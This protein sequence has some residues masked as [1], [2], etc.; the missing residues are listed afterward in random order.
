MAEEAAPKD[1]KAWM[2]KED[3]YDNDLF[4]ILTSQGIN[5][6]EEDFK[7]YTQGQW[8]ELWRKGCV[9]R[10]KEL[11]DQKAKV[12]LEK[13][14]TKLEKYW[15]KQSGV[16]STSIKKKGKKKSDTLNNSASAKNEA[17]AS[18]NEIK[19]YLKK[20]GCFSP[21]LVEV[22][23]GVGITSK[24]D[25]TNITR[26][27]YDEIFRQIRVRR[28]Q[29]LKDNAA[30]VRMEKMMEKFAKLC[31]KE[32]R[33]KSA[34]SK[35]GGKGKKKKDTPKDKEIQKMQSG[36]AK[37]KAWMRKNDVWEM[38]LYEELMANDISEAE[39]LKDIGQ[40]LFDN[41]V[42]KVRVD[43]FSQLKDQK[44]RNRA[45]KLLIKFEKEWRKASGIKKTSLKN[46]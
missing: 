6:P 29:D 36:G 18:G 17:L 46:K 32:I 41:I 44:A 14:M 42:R 2:R 25:L 43:R 33:T 24:D 38:A 20:E 7:T 16:K 1:L 30:R 37:L 10:A 9:E 15:R 13:K 39:Q 40:D 3:I 4:D 26:D 11:K 27:S 19:K 23:V 22:L 34:G 45:D 28:A 21:D 8:D 12:R 5:Q 31:P 35:K